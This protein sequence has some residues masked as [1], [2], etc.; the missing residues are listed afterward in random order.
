MDTS[1]WAN[2]NLTSL[3]CSLVYLG[4]FTIP[5]CIARASLALGDYSTSVN[6]LGQSAF[7]LVGKATSDDQYAYRGSATNINNGVWSNFPLYHAGN[8]PYTVNT[9]KLT[10]YPR[11][12]DDDSLYALPATPL[13]VEAASLI[14]SGVHPIE[15]LFFRL[16]LGEAMLGWAD[17]LYRSDDASS[18][19]RARELY[20]GIYFLHSDVPPINPNWAQAGTS[21]HNG[22][23]NPAQASQLA[24]GQL[25]FTQ[26]EAGLN[27][28]SYTD[29]MTPILRYSSLKSAA[30]A[31]AAA[32]KATENDFTH[33]MAQLE[34]STIDKMKTSNMLMR[35][36]LQNEIAQQQ[37]GIAKDQVQQAQIMVAQ[38]NQQ[39]NSLQQQINDHDSFGTQ[40]EDYIGGLVSS[41]GKLPGWFT[42]GVQSGGQA[43]LQGQEVSGL[44]G[45]GTGASILAGFGAFAVASYM[46]LSSMA[47]A[48]SQREGQLSAL[49]SQNLPSAQAQL[50]ISQRS[51]TIATL[52]GQIAQTDSDLATQLLVFGQDRY[53]SSEF[54]AYMANLFQRIFQRYLNLATQTA[55]LAQRALGYEFQSQVGIIRMDYYMPE[56]Q[57]AGSAEELQ[58]DLAALEGY[59][60]Q[61]LQERVPIKYTFSL[62]RD[63]PLQFAQLLTNGQCIFQTLEQPL[64]FAYP[65]MYGYRIISVVPTLVR[66]SSTAPLR[67]LLSNTGVSQISANDG[68]FSLSS[69]FPDALPISDFNLATTDMNI[70]GLPGNTLMPFEGSGVQTVWKLEFPVAANPSGLRDLADVLITLNLTANFSAALYQTQ[71]DQLPSTITQSIL[72]SSLQLGLGG[73][74]TLQGNSNATIAFNLGKL[75]LPALEKNRKINNIFILLVGGDNAG[76]VK[77]ALSSET[78]SHTISVSLTKGVA[79]SNNP[80]ITN[81]SSTAPPSPLNILSGATVDQTLSLVVQKSD[82]IGVNFSTVKDVLLG[83]DYIASL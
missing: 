11:L 19:P 52:N 80:P 3:V 20:K 26:I 72:I 56:N 43:A 67:G 29:D 61:G 41:I 4:V 68:S 12:S 60:L 40:L 28:F 9:A 15:Q 58:S 59:R 75:G 35:A 42:S 62:A 77:A 83:I 69:R 17:A 53:L 36:T 32:A 8:L 44:L 34:N 81:A 7:F 63:F 45:L 71:L 49:E 23:S 82:N 5:V 14:P 37:A 55:W 46:T 51:V 13:E 79:M 74:A 22:N 39:I 10:S 73:L 1:G 30:D 48:Q 54:W 25:G 50:D 27:F 78:P 66:I 65:G 76:T 2:D 47:A 57:G 33:A 21:Y 70:Y 16:Q 6:Q 18:I 64:Q 24:R 38:V 31:F